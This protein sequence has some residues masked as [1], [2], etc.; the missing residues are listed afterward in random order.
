LRNQPET[1]LTFLTKTSL[2]ISYQNNE[3]DYEQH[4]KEV[5]QADAE[6]QGK[7]A[8]PN[9]GRRVILFGRPRWWSW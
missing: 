4:K 6:H 7:S 5:H 1:G 2:T 8:K 3:N 9:I